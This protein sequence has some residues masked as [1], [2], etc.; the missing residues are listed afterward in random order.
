MSEGMRI[1]DSTDSSLEFGDA[2]IGMHALD[3]IDCYVRRKQ[4]QR[5]SALVKGLYALGI[6]LP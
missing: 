3:E 2:R 6:K 4:H 5:P 1:K